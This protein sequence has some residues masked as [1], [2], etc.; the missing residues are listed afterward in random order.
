MN[1]ELNPPGPHGQAWNIKEP[2]SDHHLLLV[3]D[4]FLNCVSYGSEEM[5][6]G[7]LYCWRCLCNQFHVNKKHKEGELK[8]MET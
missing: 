2:T 3:P 5:S 1:D 6:L 8:E 7:W 4:A